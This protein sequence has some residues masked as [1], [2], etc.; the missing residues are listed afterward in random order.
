M[1]PTVLATLAEH[2]PWAFVAAIIFW[3][4]RGVVA[5]LL[6]SRHEQKMKELELNKTH[7]ELVDAARRRRGEQQQLPSPLGTPSSGAKEAGNEPDPH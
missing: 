7:Q 5:W 3:P 6:K 4:E 2:A 1:D